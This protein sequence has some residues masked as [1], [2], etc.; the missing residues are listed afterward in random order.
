MD[1]FSKNIVG[2]EKSCKYF[3]SAYLQIG[4]LTNSGY[5][6]SHP[7][8]TEKV[9]ESGQQIGNCYSWSCPLI[10]NQIRQES[11]FREKGEV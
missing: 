5:N 3:Y 7:Y 8:Q 6:C 11:H 4:I 10:N 2:T 1:E 9:N